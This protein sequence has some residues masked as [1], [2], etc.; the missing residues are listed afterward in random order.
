MLKEFTRL[1]AK[2]VLAS[3]KEYICTRKNAIIGVGK[4]KKSAM[5]I[6]E[7]LERRLIEMSD[8]QIRDGNV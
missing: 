4:K 8:M 5:N 3:L 6:C 1:Q 7:Q 2:D